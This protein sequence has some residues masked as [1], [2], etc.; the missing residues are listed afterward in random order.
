MATKQ[1]RW[2]C[3]ACNSGVLA[4]SR[5]RRDDVRRYCLPCSAKTGK[6][7]ERIA[8][9]LEKQRAQTQAKTKRR[10]A[11]K[12]AKAVDAK[13]SHSGF[14]VEKEAARLWRILQKQENKPHKR[15]PQIKI[16]QRKRGGSSGYC[17]HG[18]R[19]VSLQLGKNT[20]DAWETVAHEL[21]H[22]IGYMGHGHDFYKCLKQLTEARWKMKV[23]SYEWTRAGYNCDWNLR[24]QLEEQKVVTFK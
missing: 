12:R 3:Q 18:G 15:L 22:A 5:P 7:V 6:L 17:E 20:V 13:T 4:P 16:V 19:F 14:D 24:R 1:I 8:P 21:V 23:N 2:K 11:T 9:T 10:Q